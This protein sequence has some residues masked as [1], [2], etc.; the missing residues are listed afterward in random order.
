[1]NIVLFESD[2]LTGQLSRKDFRAKHILKILR[3]KEGEI[4]RCGIVNGPQYSATLTEISTDSIRFS[5]Q[6]LDISDHLYPIT[7]CLGIPRPNS[8][9]RIMRDSASFG[10]QHIHLVHT[11]L[12]EKSYLKS[13]LLDLKELRSYLKEGASQAYSTQLPEV[14]ISASLSSYWEQYAQGNI[15]RYLFDIGHELPLATDIIA[16][17]KNKP[18]VVAVGSERGWTPR[19]RAQFADHG[20]QSL[21]LGA[22][23]LRT[24]TAIPA[25]LSLATLPYL[26]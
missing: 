7:L 22:R 17:E 23:V 8:I 5:T 12:G 18:M 25:I 2:E 15:L 3:L 14:S 4:F 1:M 26:R 6:K 24:D 20:F 9:R 19:E 16:K 11:E 10:I 13:H 21:K